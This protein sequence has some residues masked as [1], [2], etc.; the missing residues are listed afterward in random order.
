MHE[1]ASQVGVPAEGPRDGRAS[2]AFSVN[3]SARQDD[4]EITLLTF[5]V[6]DDL[7][8]ISAIFRLGTRSDARLASIPELALCGGDQGALDRVSAHALPQRQLVWVS[9]LYKRPVE[10]LSAYEARI[11]SVEVSHDVGRGL[12][13][14]HL[15][16]WAF[17]FELPSRLAA[18]RMLA[19]LTR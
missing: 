16:R 12:P 14:A 4:I 11:D 1:G 2:W 9:W 3:E 5:T 6:L 17:R 15:D 13:V 7:V 18:D 19:A 10:V 8:R